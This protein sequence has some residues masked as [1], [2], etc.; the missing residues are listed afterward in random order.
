[1][2]FVHVK[3][4]RIVTLFRSIGMAHTLYL[5]SSNISRSLL[6]RHRSIFVVYHRD[7]H[8]LWVCKFPRLLCVSV[9]APMGQL[10]YYGRAYLYLTID[11]T[12]NTILFRTRSLNIDEHNFIYCCTAVYTNNLAYKQGG[13]AMR[14]TKQPQVVTQHGPLIRTRCR[15]WISTLTKTLNVD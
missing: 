1:M 5:G 13:E 8:R 3:A 10:P 7:K 15:L 4:S 6:R 11:Q 14:G 9:P 12:K 2:I